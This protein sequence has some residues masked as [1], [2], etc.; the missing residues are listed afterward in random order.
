MTKIRDEKLSIIARILDN[1]VYL[2]DSGMRRAVADS[3]NALSLYT[4]RNLSLI[5][6]IKIGDTTEIATR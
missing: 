5:I 2:V 1:S 4:L 3:L 6:D